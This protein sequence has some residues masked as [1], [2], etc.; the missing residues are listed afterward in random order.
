[1]L[2]RKTSLSDN[3]NVQAKGRSTIICA[4]QVFGITAHQFQPHCLA[5]H[6]VNQ[7]ICIKWLPDI[8]YSY[9][10]M[11]QDSCIYKNWP[12]EIV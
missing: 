12:E 2:N 10:N 3:Y 1:M 9:E 6:Q 8:L 11:N 7:N 5:K 4:A